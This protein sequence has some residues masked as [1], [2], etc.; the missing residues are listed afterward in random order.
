M[1]RVVKLS[2]ALPHVCRL[3]LWCFNFLALDAQKRILWKPVCEDL[4]F[5]VHMGFQ[6]QFQS[7]HVG[8]WICFCAQGVVRK[9]Q[10]AQRCLEGTIASDWCKLKGLVIVSDS[11][12]GMAESYL[13]SLHMFISARKKVS[14]AGCQIALHVVRLPLSNVMLEH[15]RH[16][17]VTQIGKLY[18]HH[19]H[20]VL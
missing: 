19:C 9:M 1:I 5:H 8:P 14:V 20:A 4:G 7:Q 17:D 3:T 15:V 11:D 12:D 13:V 16:R 6:S 18:N 2:P 10:V